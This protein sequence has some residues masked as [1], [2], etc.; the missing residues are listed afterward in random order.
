MKSI[1]NPADLTA[2]DKIQQFVDNNHPYVLH[3]TLSSIRPDTDRA[4]ILKALLDFP[5]NTRQTYRHACAG[6]AQHSEYFQF[7]TQ[8][9]LAYHTNSLVRSGYHLS[10]EGETAAKIISRNTTYP[11][12]ADIATEA[13]TASPGLKFEPAPEQKRTLESVIHLHGLKSTVTIPFNLD[14]EKDRKGW[15]QAQ[16]VIL[17]LYKAKTALSKEDAIYKA[18]GK[19]RFSSNGA[20][21]FQKYNYLV[22]QTYGK[23]WED[24]L[25]T[26]TRTGYEFAAALEQSAGRLAKKAMHPAK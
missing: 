8:S 2:L 5:G 14:D 20:K 21:I 16:E 17:A 3:V 4:R 10:P 12:D 18:L 23:N 15:A 24:E 11:K 9:G 19:R 7:L 26:L 1:H 25:W 22:S 13:A 6:S